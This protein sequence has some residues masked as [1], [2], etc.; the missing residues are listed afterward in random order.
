MQH[1]CE[2][3]SKSV[4]KNKKSEKIADNGEF[5]IPLILIE[6]KSRHPDGREGYCLFRG[7]RKAQ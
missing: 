7:P 4:Y 1:S 5:R 6:K 2:I 3:F